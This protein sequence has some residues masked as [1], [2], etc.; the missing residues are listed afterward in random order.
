M[1][2]LLLWMWARTLGQARKGAL[3]RDFFSVRA[4]Q[5]WQRGPE[6]S[7]PGWRVKYYKVL[8]SIQVCRF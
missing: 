4:F 3:T 2:T 6:G 7:S 1:L 8:S 5:A